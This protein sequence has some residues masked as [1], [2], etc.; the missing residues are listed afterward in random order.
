LITDYHTVLVLSCP[1]SRCELAIT[2]AAL[3]LKVGKGQS[4]G[5]DCLHRCYVVGDVID[6]V[7]SIVVSTNRNPNCGPTSNPN[8]SPNRICL[9]VALAAQV[10]SSGNAALGGM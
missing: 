8:V 1:C 5:Y 3:S 2:L 9:T 7:M 4:T 6:D 10:T